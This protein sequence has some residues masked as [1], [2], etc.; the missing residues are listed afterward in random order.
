MLTKVVDQGRR[1][2]G[3]DNEQ[4]GVKNT[5]AKS[6]ETSSFT[7]ERWKSLSGLRTRMDDTTRRENN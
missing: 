4:A 6:G 5:L 1:K 7:Q 3:I 2:G